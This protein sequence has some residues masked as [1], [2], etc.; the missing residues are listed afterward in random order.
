MRRIKKDP[1]TRI[2]QSWECPPLLTQPF[3]LLLLVRALRC[4][5]RKM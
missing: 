4:K 5:D 3:I 1:L 2:G